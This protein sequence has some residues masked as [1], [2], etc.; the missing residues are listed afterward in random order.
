MVKIPTSPY[1]RKVVPLQAPV[2]RLF[3]IRL[4]KNRQSFLLKLRVCKFGKNKK[5]LFQKNSFGV[6]PKKEKEFFGK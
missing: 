1:F 2:Y 6:F 3:K 5:E 4:F